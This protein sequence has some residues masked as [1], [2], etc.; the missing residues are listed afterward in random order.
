MKLRPIIMG[1][2]VVIVVLGVAIAQNY[3]VIRTAQRDV[4]LMDTF[5]RLVADGRDA[6]SVLT[7][8]VEEMSRL[9]SIL[10]AHMLDSDVWRI[11]GAQGEPVVVSQETINV[12]EL[13]ALVYEKSNGTFDVTVGSRCHEPPAGNRFL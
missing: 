6:E 9:E 8:T 13:A 11:N 5:V 3:A 1:I 12:L 10:S 7:Q 2:I 4:L